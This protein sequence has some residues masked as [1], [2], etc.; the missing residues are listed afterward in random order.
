ML[1]AACYAAGSWWVESVRIGPQ[2]R[3]LGISYGALGDIVVFALAVA[4]HI[5]DPA[6]GARHQRGR[7]PRLALVDDSSGDVMSM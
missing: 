7:I 2:P 4:G 5:P 6:E 3:L 1:A